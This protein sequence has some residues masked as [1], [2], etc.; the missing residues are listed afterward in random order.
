MIRV[1]KSE[2]RGSFDFGWLE[3]RHTFS[4]GDYH[5]PEHMGFR[6]LRVLNED[7]V[8]PGGGF[9]MHSHSCRSGFTLPG[10]A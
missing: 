1:R 2:D 7:R 5:D 4:F 8:R 6:V 3:T 10:R 9:P